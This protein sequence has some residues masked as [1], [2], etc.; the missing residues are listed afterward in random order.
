[1]ENDQ[2]EKLRRWLDKLLDTEFNDMI[3]A[4]LTPELQ[5]SLSKPLNRGSFL[6]DMKRLDGYFDKVENHIEE[7]YHKRLSPDEESETIPELRGVPFTN[8]QNEIKDFLDYRAATYYVLHAP[9]GYGKTELLKE[10]Q[11]RFKSKGWECVYVSIS[12]S[13]TS[14]HLVNSLVNE[15]NIT[16]FFDE[17]SGTPLEWCLG[18]ALKRKWEE[19]SDKADSGLVLLIDM[20]KS[21]ALPVVK[22]L[23]EKIVPAVYNSLYSLKMFESK[24][25]PLRMI[26]AGR[27]L[28]TMEE[29]RNSSI[30]LVP[31]PLSPFD[32]KVIWDSVSK[33][34]SH[35]SDSNVKQIS[36]H[37]LYLTGGHPG[38]MAEVLGKYRDQGTPPDVFFKYVGKSVSEKIVRKISEDI[39]EDLLKHDKKL[40]EIIDYITVFRYLDSIVLKHIIDANNLSWV[41]NGYDFSLKLTATYLFE[42]K[43]YL[44]RDDITRR[45]LVIQLRDS[46]LVQFSEHC[47]EARKI[48]ANL[49]QNLKVRN[50]ERWTIEYL[51]Q[52]LQKDA[53]II[54]YPEQ[55]EKLR[56]TFLDKNVSQALQLF[57]DREDIL[58]ERL[59]EERDSLMR[60]M[61]EDWEFCFTVNYYLR[62]YEYDERPYS[63]LR[64]KISQFFDQ[65]SE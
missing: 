6:N 11:I 40:L 57:T 63:A 7:H 44:V 12:E 3:S 61:D 53:A 42:R 14:M 59:R 29:I 45:L 62:E 30:Q 17:N 28:A 55:R 9:A 65:I 38:C 50:P 31:Y 20:E 34:L 10:L 2:F 43:G 18:S 16:S 26:L 48:C 33:Y 4:L 39:R 24:Q 15:L 35:E 56:E 22:D 27:Y 58:V 19:N 36:A 64:K 52:S 5:N 37:L 32:Y 41:N 49:I 25:K 21:P 13:D 46:D 54:Q 8:R 51:F 1:M 47:Q 60:M 23:L